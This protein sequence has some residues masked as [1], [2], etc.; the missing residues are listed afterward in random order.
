MA[1]KISLKKTLRLSENY[2]NIYPTRCNVT[3]FSSSG[4]CSTCFGW[5]HRSSSGAQTTVPTASGIFHTVIAIC[6]YRG[7]VGTG[8]CVLWV[9][10]INYVMLHL[11]V[12]IYIYIYIYI[13]MMHGPMNVKFRKTNYSSICFG[14]LCLMRSYFTRDSISS[15]RIILYSLFIIILKCSSI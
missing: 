11:V 14:L 13:L 4:N 12:Y 5:Y 10:Y 3:Q 15:F 2:S 9:A 1:V 7:R 8:L 6:R